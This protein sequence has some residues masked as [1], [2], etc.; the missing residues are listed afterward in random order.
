MEQTAPLH[1]Q[2]HRVPIHFLGDARDLQPFDGTTR[3]YLARSLYIRRDVEAGRAELDAA[4]HLARG[5]A[6]LLFRIGMLAVADG[7][8]QDLAAASLREAGALEP[9]WFVRA[10]E[11][12]VQRAPDRLSEIVPDRHFAWTIVAR[13]HKNAGRKKEAIAAYERAI[14]LGAEGQV[15]L[16]LAELKTQ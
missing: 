4:H 10:M 11:L 6:D 5:D 1:T 2:L 13:H 12:V 7:D 16:D 14:E 3:Y 15:E 8:R 9:K